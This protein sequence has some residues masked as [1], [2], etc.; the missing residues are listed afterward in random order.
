MSASTSTLTITHI[1]KRDG[2]LAP[3]DQGK[4][5]AA[6]AK[7]FDATYKPGSEAVAAQLAEEV[8]A[9][10]E[11]EGEARPEV[12]HVQDLVERVLMENG[13]VQT[14]KAYILYRDD[15]SRAREMNTRL[16]KIYED[17]TFAAAKDSDIKREN[18][19]IDGD[20]GG[21]QGVL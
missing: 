20:L 2:R 12:E 3:F 7:A 4:I 13:Y 6:I 19:N 17:I 15:R 11:V 21:R 5:A 1:K 16:M 18:A 9:L 8:R 10:L 14:A